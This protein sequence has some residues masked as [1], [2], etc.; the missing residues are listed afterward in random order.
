MNDKK[1]RAWGQFSIEQ[2]IR[3]EAPRARVFEA[4]ITDINSWW[5]YR[6]SKEGTSTVRLE[7]RVGGAFFEDFGG[8][9]GALW[10]TVTYIKAPEI[11]RLD[12]P[13]GM[14][15][16]VSSTYTYDLVEADRATIIHLSHQASGFIDPKWG[17]AHGAGW[18]ELLGRLLKGW[19]EEGKKFTEFPN[20]RY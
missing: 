5:A 7:P 18:G 12:G 3:I 4:L 17:E 20:R 6:F 10:G 2:E 9:E 8:G 16:A 15:T 13:L 19:V 1:N 11:L 14:D